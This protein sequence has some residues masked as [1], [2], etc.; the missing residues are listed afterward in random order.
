MKWHR[1]CALALLSL[2]LIILSAGYLPMLAQQNAT[3][4]SDLPTRLMP[5][6]L[7]DSPQVLLP[8]WQR[9]SF[10]SMPPIQNNGF[11]IIEGNTRTWSAGQTPDRYLT[12]LDIQSPL[13]PDLLNLD[14]IGKSS[15]FKT[16]PMTSFPLLGQQTIKHLVD[17]VPS[18]GQFSMRQV[19]PIA[20][21]L[22][23]KGS[24]SEN[25]TPLSTLL[26]QNPNLGELKLNQIDLSEYAIADIPNIE[27][28]QLGQFSGWQDTLIAD[29]PNLN[30]L[31]LGSFPVPLTELGNAV[32]RIDFIWS[33]AEQ[34]RLRTIS[35]SDVAGFSVPCQGQE[36]PH[37][38][39]DDLE[40]SGRNH[41][42]EFEGR[43][44]ISGK[45][46]QV[47]GGWGCLKGV[48][49]G[50]EPTGR[51]PFGSFAKVV[52]MEPDEK[53]DTV[54]TALFFRFKTFCGATPYFIGPVPFLTYRVNAP[55]F[56][57]ILDKQ[58]QRT[59]SVPQANSSGSAFAS[60]NEEALSQTEF[61][62]D[63]PCP[64]AASSPAGVNVAA[65]K[66][67]IAFLE[68]SG[69]SDTIGP[70]VCADRGRNCG[71]ALGKYQDMSYNP[72]AA[73][74]IANKPGGQE[75]LSKL[76]TGANVTPHELFQFYPPADQ[77]AAVKAALLDKITL[78][79][80]EIDP[81]TGLPFSG[82][83][84]I[85]RV[86]QKHFGGDGS[87]VDGGATDA[88]GRLSLKSYG[89]DV[90][91]RYKENSSLCRL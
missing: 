50:K 23:Q 84:L 83:R 91:Q 34:K 55:I 8:D 90:L 21:L 17:I 24:L 75:W 11:S 32:A 1:F 65:L 88:F 43:S 68:S 2:S 47:E 48:N 44:W 86:A 54:D 12:L 80:T 61:A 40:N 71:R 59:V 41:R 22:S 64:T 15:D 9:I 19:P 5:S 36:C 25:T 87:I 77:E 10:G 62:A 76:N 39:L 52:V 69:Q 78:T 28:V 18:L 37:I 31:P 26:I 20:A 4:Q 30:T 46:Q 42:G 63:E 29:V 85:E 3:I 57:G 70:F 27:S 74:A 51:L 79:S 33:K 60:P 13:R 72:Y 53:T 7:S 67:A 89:L 66:N 14:N 16:I 73:Q 56:I 45:Y 35:G 81:T 49:G 58:L 6:V 82:D 38:E